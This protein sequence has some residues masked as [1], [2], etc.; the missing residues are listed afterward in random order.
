MA[1][2]R[3]VVQYKNTLYCNEAFLEGVD[4]SPTFTKR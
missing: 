2:H 1:S 3:F 4:D